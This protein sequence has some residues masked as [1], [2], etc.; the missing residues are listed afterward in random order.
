MLIFLDL[1]GVLADM[2]RAA[3]AVHGRPRESLAGVGWDLP[4]QL[5]LSPAEFWFLLGFDFWRDL[6]WHDD[7]RKL[8][9][10][11]EAAFAPERIFL[12]SSPCQTPGCLEGKV[13]WVR[14]HLPNYERRLI[15]TG[16]KYA[17]ASRY[18]LLVD[19]HEGNVDRWR[20][21]G[22]KGVLVPRPWNRHAHLC[23]PQG[24][25]DPECVLAEI[26]MLVAAE[27]R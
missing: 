19:D 15:L 11:L 20:E 9:A 17:I 13:A 16:A 5:N 4:G 10:G 21:Y 14:Q 23:D 25:F 18:K 27:E 7:G 26:E 22:G 24:N 1:D 2:V 6:D 12:A 3:F 8:F